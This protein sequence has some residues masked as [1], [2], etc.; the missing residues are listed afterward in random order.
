MKKIETKVLFRCHGLGQLMTNPTGKSNGQKYA[1]TKEALSKAEIQLAGF[2]EKAVVM[3][4][5]TAEKI[6]K[7]KSEIERLE[8]IKDEV[9]LSSTAKKF[10][11]T[12]AIEIRYG[13]KKR[14]ENKYTKK[15][16]LTEDA[17][18]ELY[19]E[20]KGEWYENNKQRKENDFFTGE[21]DIEIK[22]KESKV[23]AVKDIKTRFDIDTFNDHRD[24]DV[25]AKEKEQLLGY[26]DLLDCEKASIVNVLT[27][28][29]YSLILDEIRKETFS[30][31][32]DDLAGFDVPMARVLEIGKDNIFDQE[33]FDSFI[34]QFFSI[35]VLDQLKSGET[36]IA[37]G[38][39][40]PAIEMYQSFVEV[41]LEERIIE[42]EIEFNEDEINAIKQR[43][44]ECRKYLASVWNIHHIE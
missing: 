44:I 22:S 18:I 10:L 32:A 13:R 38:V 12:M 7:L 41:P 23:I 28:N 20:L 6:E 5:K 36:S 43:L 24:E 31:K 4:Q 40:L 34:T 42:V 39:D 33:S 19:S 35:M 14:M 25:N 17:S 2:S 27:N 8:P 16:N 37:L 1:E 3:K 15:G 21:W 9:L 26:C 11:K 29:D 30:V